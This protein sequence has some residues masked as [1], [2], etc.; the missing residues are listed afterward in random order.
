MDNKNQ[1]LNGLHKKKRN[2]SKV[3]SLGDTGGNTKYRH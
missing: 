2:R 1:K 3:P